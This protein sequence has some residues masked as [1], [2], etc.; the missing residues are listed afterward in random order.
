MELQISFAR[1]LVLAFTFV[2]A[3]SFVFETEALAAPPKQPKPDPSL[4]EE[5]QV[6]LERAG[7][8]MKSGKYDKAR[9][10]ISSALES[11][12]DVPKCLAIAQFTELYG[13]PMME[14]RRQC[15]VKAL[16]L[17]RT[18]DDLLLMAL[19]ARKYQ[20][21]EVTRMAIS[22][23][24]EN[25]K[26]LPQL[27]ELAKRAQEVAL[28]DVAH[29]AM[30]KA[31]TGLKSQDDAF[32]YASNCKALGIDDLTRKALKQMIDDE[33]DS[34]ALC[35]MAL[36]IQKYGMR[37]EVRYALRKALDHTSKELAPATQEMVTISETARQVN[38]P[39]V[40]A[41]ADYFVKKGNVMLRQQQQSQIDERAARAARER[42]S[43]DAARAADANRESS[44]GFGK[45]DPSSPNQP[46][47]QPQNAST[48]Y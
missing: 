28:N 15:C 13:F 8:Y 18:E 24:I 38:E 7:K 23:L 19:K 47:N 21:F 10:I 6:S 37:D 34:V 30:E 12:N 31:Y 33:D 35:D 40:K 11:A 22:R 32:T 26:T 5:T 29:L 17:C 43:L 42:A 39:D 36:K 27:Y 44:A 14:L 20:F 25:A 4:A 2:S 46:S 45:S 41:R 1:N 9:P 3:V 16:N 48:G